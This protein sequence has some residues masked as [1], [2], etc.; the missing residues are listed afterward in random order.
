MHIRRLRQSLGPCGERIETVSGVGYRFR[1]Q[2][3]LPGGWFR[4]ESEKGK[5]SRVTAG[6]R[7][8]NGRGE[9]GDV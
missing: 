1:R 2:T 7:A 5:G 6:A 9:G 4:V 8:A 3:H